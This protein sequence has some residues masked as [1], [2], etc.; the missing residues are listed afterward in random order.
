M[1][2]EECELWHDF[3][4]ERKQLATQ[5]GMLRTGLVEGKSVGD[6]L[7]DT[8]CSRTLVHQRLVSESKL[9]EGDATG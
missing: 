3:W 9:K 8:G 6:I 4:C 5:P 1:L 2:R 7:L